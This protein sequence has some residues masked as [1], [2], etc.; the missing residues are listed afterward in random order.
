MT[1]SDGKSN[2]KR[3]YKSSSW[4][5]FSYKNTNVGSQ[6]FQN[7]QGLILQ[8]VSLS[9]TGNFCGCHFKEGHS[10]SLDPLSKNMKSLGSWQEMGTQKL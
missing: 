10:R 4:Q 2:T 3:C 9:W 5:T 6:E 1:D 8:E 7:S